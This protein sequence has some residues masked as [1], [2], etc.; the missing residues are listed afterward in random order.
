MGF[1]TRTN[2]GDRSQFGM[3][4]SEG[5]ICSLCVFKAMIAPF[6]NNFLNEQRILEFIFQ[7][8]EI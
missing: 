1:W 5:Y 2:A 4:W 6:A 3:K 8:N 7:P